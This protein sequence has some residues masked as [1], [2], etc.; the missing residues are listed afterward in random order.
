MKMVLKID[1]ILRMGHSCQSDL[2]G[3]LLKLDFTRKYT[4][5]SRRRFRSLT[6]VWLS[7]ESLSNSTYPEG[8]ETEKSAYMLQCLINVKT[9]VEVLG[10]S[11]HP[12]IIPEGRKEQGSQEIRRS[13]EK[14]FQA[15]LHTSLS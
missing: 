2:V 15:H 10:S 5:G 1:Q 7:K 14:N 8:F 13:L 11:F 12:D 3:F 6:K 4:D 9:P